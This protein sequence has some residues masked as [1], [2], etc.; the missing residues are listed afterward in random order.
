MDLSKRMYMCDVTVKDS[1]GNV[2]RY[3]D[4]EDDQPMTTELNVAE[5]DLELTVIPQMVNYKKVVSE[6]E[7]ENWK[8]KLAKKIAG[9]LL[10]AVDKCLLRVGCKYNIRG[11]KEN[12]TVYLCQKEYL[13]TAFDRLVLLELLP[14]TYMFFEAFHNGYRCQMTDAFG[15]NRKDVISF[16]RKITLANFGFHLIFTYPFQVGRIKRLTSDRKVKK[17]LIGFNRM[18]DEQRQKLLNRMEKMANKKNL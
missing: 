1:V 13:C 18:S 15:T 16:S 8:E 12:D 2:I 10:S 17:K 4:S 11:L 3:V 6:I 5:G 9:K 7:A 14:V